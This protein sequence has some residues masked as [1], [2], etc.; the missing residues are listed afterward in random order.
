MATHVER[1]GGGGSVVVTDV[2]SVTAVS[3]PMSHPHGDPHALPLSPPP[4]QCAPP[5][6]LPLSVWDLRP[7]PPVV[8][9]VGF[10]LR[11]CAGPLW[12]ASPEA[13][14]VRVSSWGTVGSTV[15]LL[16]VESHS[17]VPVGRE[18]ISQTATVRPSGRTASCSRLP[19]VKPRL[20]DS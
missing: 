11:D 4:R 17:A 16:L 15:S 7:V 5:S 9:T 18:K 13:W 1:S 6:P 19:F 14:C 12:L 10:P 2:H 20:C 8:S 3:S